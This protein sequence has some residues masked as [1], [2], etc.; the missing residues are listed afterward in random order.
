V[1]TVSLAG[2]VF[3]DAN[4]NGTQEANDAGLRGWRVFIDK[5][6]DGVLDKNEYVVRTSSSGR[7]EFFDL[8]VGTYTVRVLG[9]VEF[10]ATTNTS[11][12]VKT[13]DSSTVVRRFGFGQ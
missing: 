5:D 12:R 4:R 2:T 7:F 11:F 9:Y 10:V 8:G 13:T 1:P 3:R 6:N